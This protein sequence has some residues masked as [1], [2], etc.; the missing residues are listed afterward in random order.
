MKKNKFE[1]YEDVAAGF[2]TIMDQLK[3]AFASSRPGHLALGSHGT[4]YEK[5]VQELEAFLRPLWGFA[6]YLTQ[7]EDSFMETYL[8]GI[9]A[10]TDP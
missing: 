3:P 7:Q 1:S 4:V 8:S 10:G 9:I 2:K 6:P 5:E